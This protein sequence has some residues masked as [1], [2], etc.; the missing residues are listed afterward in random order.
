MV[1]LIG[2]LGFG[3]ASYG[4][5]LQPGYL[6][7]RLIDENVYAV[8]WKVPIT[9]DRP[10]AIT[11]QLPEHCDPRTPGQ[12]TWDGA[13]YVSR[14]TATCPGGLEGGQIHIDGLDK[15][16][17]DVLVRFDFVN[18]DNQAHRLTAA[19]TTFIVPAQPSSLEVVRT[20]FPLG[21]EHILSG[22]DHLL[23]VLALLI[24]VK[25]TRRIVVTVTAFTIA[26]SFTLAGATLGFVNLPGPPVEA[27]I[28]LSI[29][30]VASE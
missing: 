24:L 2:S 12:P 1:L 28:A 5:A 9:G 3:G 16:S 20:Y 23:F 17:T 29:A 7:L 26:H 22:I 11:A 10:M 13:A 25:G 27:A 15:T 8:V 18:G 14:W 30:F 4:H 21:V 19:D 6:E